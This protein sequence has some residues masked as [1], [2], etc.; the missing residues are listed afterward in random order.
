MY[1]ET[2]NP[3]IIVQVS[4]CIV[5]EICCVPYSPFGMFVV[6]STYVYNARYFCA[7]TRARTHKHILIETELPHTQQGYS[8]LE[9][10]TRSNHNFICHIMRIFC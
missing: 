7:Y 4:Q 9:S 6:L 3:D 5:E 10:H 2:M 1:Q 8:D